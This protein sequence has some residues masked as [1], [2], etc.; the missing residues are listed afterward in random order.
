MKYFYSLLFTI[1]IFSQTIAQ[2]VSINANSAFRGATL[3]IHITLASGV[4]T[5]T[6][7]PQGT[8]DIFL[9]QGAN[10]IYT[11]YFDPTQVYGYNPWGATTDSL[12][13]DFTIPANAQ[14][15]WYDVH[16]ISYLYDPMAPWNPFTPVDNVLQN[17]FLVPAVG[18][19]AVPSGLSASA[20][21]NT[22][23]QINW[24]APTVADTFRIRY[25][26][27][28][29]NYFYK[30]INGS[31]G[32]VNTSLSNLSP[33]TT[34]Y[35]DISTICTGISSTYSVPV[36]SF[37]TS[38]TPVSC[39]VPNLLSSSAVT[40]TTATV[41]WN[42]LITADNFLVRYR[43]QGGSTYQYSLVAGASFST[44]FSNL[45]PGTTY[46]YQV[47]S[48]CTGVSSGYSAVATF[49]TTSVAANCIRPF[50]ISAGSITNNSAV[51]SWTNLVL[52]DTFR[53]RYAE[54]NS[55]NYSYINSTSP[56][57]HSTTLSNLH[58]GTTYDVQISSICLGVSTAYSTV[59]SF[60]TLS[61][62]LSCVRPFGLTT[63][64][65]TNTSVTVDWTNFVTADTFRIRYAVFGTNN[66]RYINVNGG[67][68]HSYSLTG[69][70]PATT[71]NVQISSICTGV[72]SG[73]CPAVSFTTASTAV[74]CVIPWGLSSSNTANTSVTVSWSPYV[75]AD[76]FRV[77]YR[78][79]GGGN[80][81][82]INQN[83]AAGNSLTIS[84][85]QANTLYQYQVSS[86]CL[87]VSSGY[88]STSFFT[89][90]SIPVSCARP[91][92]T[93]TTNITNVSALLNWT[94]MVS[95]DTFRI[96]YAEQG[97][98]NYHYIN[99]PGASGN[100]CQLNNLNPNTTYNFQIS[101]ICTGSSSGYSSNN[102]FT[103]TNA[104]VACAI[105]YGLASSNLTNNSADVSWTPLVTAD[106]FLVRYSV[107]GTTNYF[108]KQIPGNIGSG[109]TLTGLANNTTYQW[110]VRT[111]CNGQPTSSYS[112]S[113]TFGTLLRT[114]N[115]KNDIYEV[116]PNPTHDKITVHFQ[117]ETD[118][119]TTIILTD[120]SGRE[121]ISFER[122]SDKGD[123][124]FEVELGDLAPGVYILTQKTGSD[125]KQTQIVVY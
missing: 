68:A 44:S 39:I 38:S 99:Q 85:L 80:Y 24:T 12:F 75:A 82:Y 64:G 14:L 23:A 83:G 102:S 25:K 107:N 106:S 16:V 88:S 97:S 95:A 27:A 112:A 42:N 90:L 47:S 60:T 48:I 3:T 73:Y 63:T 28:T 7:S 84:N 79:V 34:Y 15:G 93:S 105:P 114:R 76:T 77:R 110:Q 113:S 118:D 61:T 69:L 111:I 56:I 104:P 20:I 71:Y 51:I 122:A 96:R 58:P 121:L 36:L 74:S 103:T 53:I 31:G 78:E 13:T 108:W 101:S 11:N 124:Y 91:H 26:T 67:L 87:G 17:G 22:S 45:Q 55:I 43:I 8:S 100:S 30:D 57:P 62:P 5:I 46:E 19:C 40:N 89:T 115:L 66:Y 65:L 32:A 6:S 92:T 117:A 94:N 10:T 59:Y 123:N 54:Q 98:F 49:T 86:I 50:G 2:V 116:Y 37:T 18:S 109:T 33:G 81:S 4:I 119:A 1:F 125:Y 72:S 41:S 52:A 9:Q 35:V 29:S 21:T 120:L 70:Q